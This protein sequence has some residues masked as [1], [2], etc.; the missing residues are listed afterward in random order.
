MQ[1]ERGQAMLRAAG[2]RRLT[3]TLSRCPTG[4]KIARRNAL[5]T[6][7]VKHIGHSDPAD[8]FGEK[9]PDTAFWNAQ[10]H[11]TSANTDHL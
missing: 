10:I 4:A 3:R 5:C 7:D 11:A 6:W 8:L 1:Q 2:A 9:T